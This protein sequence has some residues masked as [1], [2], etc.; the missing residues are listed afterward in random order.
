MVREKIAI[1]GGGRLGS[2]LAVALSKR[3]KI[4]IS[5]PNS[6][7]LFELSKKSKNIDTTLVNVE[8]ADL[9][10]LVVL[11]VKPSIVA[12]SIDSMKSSLTEKLLVSCAAGTSIKKIESA[13]AVRVIRMMPNICAEVGEAMLAY[14]VGTNAT[15]EDERHFISVFSGIGKC[16]K[17]NENDLDS[18]TVASGSGPA[19]FSFFAKAVY[20]AAVENG[21]SPDMAKIAVGQT[22]VGTGKLLLAGK[23][24][25][26]IIKTVASP[27]GT[28][29]AGLNALHAEG[30]EPTIAKAVA[31][32]IK[33]A[34][35]MEKS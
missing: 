2:T 5:D 8:A 26:D 28:T 27:G 9:G 34:K 24:F 21:L 15:E 7:R 29:E 22:L 16:V 3:H 18:I 1:I 35:E 10:A 11:A 20:S 12:E 31:E 33:K 17:V 30:V 25:D 19:F 13:G 32:G 23:D 14:S 6:D 4:V